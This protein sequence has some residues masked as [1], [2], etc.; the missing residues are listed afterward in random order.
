A[1][2]KH[3]SISPAGR[4]ACDLAF[5]QIAPL[6]ADVVEAVGADRVRAALP[7]LREMRVKLDKPDEA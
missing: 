7:V 5:E 6:L 1:R 3:V 2:R 4:R